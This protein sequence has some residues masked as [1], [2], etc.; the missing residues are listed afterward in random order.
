M[1]TVF[2]YVSYVICILLKYVSG[3]FRYTG[4]VYGWRTYIIPIALNWVLAILSAIQFS[5]L[6]LYLAYPT[7]H[8]MFNLY[9]M[10]V[11]MMLNQYWFS[12]VRF[13]DI[14]CSFHTLFDPHLIC[15]MQNS[16]KSAVGTA[17]NVWPLFLPVFL[18]PQIR[19]RVWQSNADDISAMVQ[20]AIKVKFCSVTETYI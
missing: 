8:A 18:I 20:D 3:N 10:S 13:L 1:Y 2:A 17:S 15:V 12:V 19:V 9:W 16:A 14:Y 11:I 4:K 7:G 5:C 6:L